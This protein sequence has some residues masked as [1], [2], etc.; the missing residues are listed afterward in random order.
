MMQL[1][2]NA[3]TLY[4]YVFVSLLM[5]ASML[6]TPEPLAL[7]MQGR[8]AKPTASAYLIVMPFFSVCLIPSHCLV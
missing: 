3:S 4:V 6:A 7:M 1:S 5:V 8:K 2:A